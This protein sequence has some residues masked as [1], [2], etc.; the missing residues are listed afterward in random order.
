MKVSNKNAIL[1][2]KYV[3]YLI[4]II[5]LG[6]LLT[7]AYT[8]DYYSAS[9]F[10]LIGFLTSFFSKNMI[11][12]LFIAIAFTNIIKYGAKAGVE[13]MSSNDSDENASETDS[14]TDSDE[15][16]TK[17]TDKKGKLKISE[18]SK[19]DTDDENEKEK[20]KPTDDAL[21]LSV[22]TN[23]GTNK[24]KFEQDKN[25]V[26]TSDEDKQMDKTDKMILSQEKILK[27]MNKYKPLLDTLQG[28][29]KNM[30]IVKG[31]TS[32]SDE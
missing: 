24:E 22:E 32:V 5:A 18:K 11:V 28:I 9:I 29:T 30:A 14:E 15:K 27:S 8:Y 1:H 7:L 20:S 16:K 31:A 4:F 25:V 21:S 26:Y 10:V 2:N 23:E 3:L 17:D 13:G 6:N 19:K 12:I